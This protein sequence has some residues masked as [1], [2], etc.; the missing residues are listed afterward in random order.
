MG[1]SQTAA[2][3]LRANRAQIRDLF[4]A[5]VLQR[6]GE[7]PGLL[8]AAESF[9]AL[10]NARAEGYGGFLFGH[11]ARTAR[12]FGKYTQDFSALCDILKKSRGIRRGDPEEDQLI[13]YEMLKQSYEAYRFY[14]LLAQKTLPVGADEAIGLFLD[15]SR[16]HY[17]PNDACLY[18][19]FVLRGG[20]VRNRFDRLTPEDFLSRLEEIRGRT[21]AAQMERSLAQNRPGRAEGPPAP[22]YTLEY[23]DSLTGHQFEAFVKHLLERMGYACRLTP[24]SNDQ[25]I[26]IIA[27][28]AAGQVGV[29]AK[30]YTGK[31]GNS[32][33]Q[34]VVAGVA[35]YGLDRALVV[36]NSSFTP[37][38]VRLAASNG[39]SLWG[40][41]ELQD[42]LHALIVLDM[43]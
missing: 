38:A 26:D 20:Y 9:L 7:M 10:N 19:D 33:V 13:V 8:C 30:C 36:T 43:I 12:Q 40:R 4:R 23:V 17:D 41:S 11:D 34:E 15:Y 28:G 27:T 21:H 14:P 22:E 6:P 16:G 29:Q 24:G 18:A 5:F 42:K 37:A 39:V 2:K 32:A 31:V 25:G 3:I 35:H 1:I